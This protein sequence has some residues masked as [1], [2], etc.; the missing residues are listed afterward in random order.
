MRG[1]WSALPWRDIS[2]ETRTRSIG[3]LRPVARHSRASTSGDHYDLM[4]MHSL[5]YHFSRGL[6]CSLHPLYNKGSTFC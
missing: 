4:V 1:Q 5:I 2:T 6:R 3:R